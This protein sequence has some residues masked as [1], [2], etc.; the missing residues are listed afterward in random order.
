MLAVVE[1]DETAFVGQR[2]DQGVDDVVVIGFD[3]DGLRN[4]C[5]DQAGVID[6]G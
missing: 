5:W 2:G 6:V 3:T 1:D 4:L